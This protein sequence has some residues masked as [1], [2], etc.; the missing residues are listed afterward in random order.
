MDN[1]LKNI[2]GAAGNYVSSIPQ[3][4]TGNGDSTTLLIY[5]YITYEHGTSRFFADSTTLVDENKD[6]SFFTA[7]YDNFADNIVCFD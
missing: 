4:A 7:A 3:N 2:V 5:T 1:T 6:N